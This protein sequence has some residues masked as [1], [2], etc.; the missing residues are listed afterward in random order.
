VIVWAL[1]VA[2][3]MA[4][5]WLLLAQPSIDHTWRHEVSHFWLVVAVA[6]VSVVLGVRMST[7]ARHRSDTRL[8]LVAC[9]FL[10][11][12][13]F[14]LLHALATPGVLVDHPNI[15]FDLAQP[16][17][18]A[19]AAVFAAASALPLDSP[20][21]AGLLGRRG[22]GVLRAGLVLVLLA[23]ATVSLLDLPPLNQPPQPRDVSGALVPVAVGAVLL[24][25]AA[26]AR[27][28]QLHRRAPA[29]MLIS[30]VTAFALLAEAMVTVILA[31]KWQLSWWEW[32]VLLAFGFGFVAYSAHV[33]YR[34]EGSSAGLF[35]AITLDQTARRIRAEYG[36]ALEQLVTVLQERERTGR[37]GT[38]PVAA[39]LADRFGLTEGQVAV[40]DRA[41][42]ALA[43]ERE[44]SR[45]LA[46][47]AAIG[48]QARVGLAEQD[49]IADAVAQI[50]AGYGDVRIGL[51]SG[52]TLRIDDRQYAPEALAGGPDERT[53]G[54]RT[55]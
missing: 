51:I 5:L 22:P 47:L 40:L 20:R 18:L 55:R 50:R 7:A 48:E 37:G 38:E 1:H 16:V 6:L 10:A 49:F 28:Y 13:G 29:A 45:R 19:I 4:G 33:Q 41:G 54:W 11:S 27:Y 53:A 30:I 8:F 3:P 34:R 52:G 21:L 25:L 23:W 2:L 9:A 32:H 36:A 44:L 17:G 14:L 42:A 24:Y 35:D 46:A 26:A 31:P 15:G 39:R 43:A 12:A